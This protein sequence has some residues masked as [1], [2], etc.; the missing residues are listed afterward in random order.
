MDF[1]IPHFPSLQYGTVYCIGRNYVDH[2]QEMNSVQTSTPVVFLKPRSSIIHN[3]GTVQIP[4]QSAN[5][6]HEAEMVLLIGKTTRNA[7]A[8]QALHSVKGVGVGIDF[9]ARDL[10]SRAKKEGLPWT[11]AKGFD[12]FAPVGPFV[13]YSENIN[14][15]DLNISLTVNGDEKQNDSTSLMIFPPDEIISYLSHQFTL[16]PGDLIF[17]G[18]PKGVSPVQ[19]GDK[20]TATLGDELSRIHVDVQ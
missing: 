17:T 18:T 14:L 2:I 15:S 10:Q 3:E 16:T 11:L 5:V 6:H 7:S 13:E 19:T 1:K 4:Q 8:G 20:I 9:T 12:T